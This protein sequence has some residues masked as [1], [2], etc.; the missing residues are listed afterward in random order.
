MFRRGRVV[1]LA[2]CRRLV[3]AVAGFE[4]EMRTRTD[5]ELGELTVVF[6]RRLA[7]GA[8]LNDLLPEAFAAVCEAADRALGQRHAAVQVMGGVALH[9]GAIADMRTGEGKT[10]TAA[11]G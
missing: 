11:S 5:A 3:A 6:R 4:A 7:D 2:R 9:L 10:L 1:D 8:V